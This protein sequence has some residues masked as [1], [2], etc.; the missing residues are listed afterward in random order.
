M[1]WRV[2]GTEAAQAQL[3]DQ[4]VLQGLMG[5]FYTPFCRRGVGVNRLNVQGL[6]GAGKWG[7]FA[8]LIWM[9]DPQD[10]VLSA[11]N[12]HRTALLVKLLV[13]GSPPSNGQHAVR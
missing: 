10:T 13:R 1:R 9:I 7:W 12:G 5:S 6:E 2:N 8:F 3:L 11:I 4:S